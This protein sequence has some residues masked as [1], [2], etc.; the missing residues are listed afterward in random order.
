MAK[1]IKVLIVDDETEIREFVRF[2]VESE[3][4]SEVIVAADGAQA[5]SIFKEQPDIELIF[6][7]Y[8]MPAADGADVYF[9]V[10]EFAASHPHLNPKF[11]LCSAHHQKSL[12]KLASEDLFHVVTKPHIVEGIKAA[13]AKY[14][15][16]EPVPADKMRDRYIPV[17]TDFLMNLK[18]EKTD[19]F[20]R[21]GDCKFI[22]LFSKNDGPLQRDY[23]RYKEKGIEKLFI[24][25]EDKELFISRS[26]DH[27]AD[28]F[29][30]EKK[31]DTQ[32]IMDIQRA[33]AQHVSAFGISPEINEVV[34]KNTQMSLDLISKIPD[35]CAFL[36]KLVA[37]QSYGVEHSLIMAAISCAIAS[38]MNWHSEAT[39]LKLTMACLLH[40]MALANPNYDRYSNLDQLKK[41]FPDLSKHALERYS[42][43]PQ[44][45][46]E[47]VKKL[48]EVPPDI[49]RII[50]EH[51]EAPDGTGF[52]RG[53]THDRLSML[54]SI[55][56][57]A[58]QL[59]DLIYQNI[60]ECEGKSLVDF[61]PPS[62]SEKGNFKKIHEALSNIK[63]KKMKK[64]ASTA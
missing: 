48:K 38:E 34:R 41:D 37:G 63:Q 36:E 9:F 2:L 57:V 11:V 27:L 12:E 4:T 49:D 61:L 15:L 5:I 33:V 31:D 43:H 52:P 54:G 35:L 26:L 21:L 56:I 16:Q 45:G 39:Y 13:L 32:K 40:D 44:L 30:D 14:L 8:N 47:I 17:Q 10:K 24:K 25:A 64:G 18:P 3:V 29:N 51:H 23:A 20:V 62:Y 60:A 46:S 6:C 19:V 1:S 22:K 28:L 50:L 58:H 55:V 7:D 53:L 42:K 59:C